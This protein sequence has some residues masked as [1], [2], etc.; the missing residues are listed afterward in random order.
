MHASPTVYTLGINPNVLDKP[1]TLENA[2]EEILAVTGGKAH[3]ELMGRSSSV[4]DIP[5]PA[6]KANPRPLSQAQDLHFLKF[7]GD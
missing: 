6:F 2:R 4:G 1:E 7:P 5:P 3:G